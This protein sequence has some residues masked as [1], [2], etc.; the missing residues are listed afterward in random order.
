MRLRTL[1]PKTIVFL[2]NAVVSFAFF[3]TTTLLM[4][5]YLFHTAQKLDES[6]VLQH[7]ILSMFFVVIYETISPI[8]TRRLAPSQLPQETPSQRS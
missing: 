5:F 1:Y 2:R 6:F 3:F 4:D 8:L 7:L